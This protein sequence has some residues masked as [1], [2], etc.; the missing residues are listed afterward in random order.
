MLAYSEWVEDEVL[1]PIPH[2]QYV[3]TLPKLL[4]PHF[5]RRHRLVALCQIVAALLSGAYRPVK[6]RSGRITARSPLSISGPG[7][8]L[9]N[10]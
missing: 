5:H 9:R 6:K 2:R 4:R 7:Y 10:C 8:S 1:H 3:F